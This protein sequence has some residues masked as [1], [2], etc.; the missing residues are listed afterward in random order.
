WDLVW[1]GEVTNDTPAALRAFLRPPRERS[2][3]ARRL[4]AFRSRR[5]APP[6]AVGRWSRVM[7]SSGA[8]APTPTERLKAAAEQL[9][10][11]HG[12]VTR[13]AV[14]AEGVSG[15]FAA[16][17]PVLRALE[18]AGRVRRGYFVAGLGGSQFALPGALERLRAL[19]E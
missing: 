16:V 18:E 19:K 1:A 17:Y 10:A 12:V 5:L 9:L 6:R 4:A 11:R 7:P 3:P 8:K 15:G 2:L 13:Q 14:L